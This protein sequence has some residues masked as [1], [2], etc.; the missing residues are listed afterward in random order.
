MEIQSYTGAAI[1]HLAR[2]T[3]E[4]TKVV[5]ITNSLD[6][7]AILLQSLHEAQKEADYGA[8]TIFE[9]IAELKRESSP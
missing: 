2:C 7:K 6:N 3:L 4:L 1:A 8:A 9:L 5:P